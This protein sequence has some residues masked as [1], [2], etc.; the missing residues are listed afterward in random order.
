MKPEQ[1]VSV[2]ALLVVSGLILRTPNGMEHPTST[3]TDYVPKIIADS[4]RY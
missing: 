2:C 4:T 3:N 1:L